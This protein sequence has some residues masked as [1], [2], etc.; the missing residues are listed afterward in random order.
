MMSAILSAG[1]TKILHGRAFDTIPTIE[2]IFGPSQAS[3]GHP[4]KHLAYPGHGMKEDRGCP[5]KYRSGTRPEASA[6]APNPEIQPTLLMNPIGLK[7]NR[8]PIG[9]P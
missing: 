8:A 2:R 4:D 9:A 5:N 1:A 7:V 3:N 6:D